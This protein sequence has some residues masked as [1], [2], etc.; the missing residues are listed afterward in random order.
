MVI[1]AKI[2]IFLDA[3]NGRKREEKHHSELFFLSRQFGLEEKKLIVKFS[4]NKTLI[5]RAKARLGH[6]FAQRLIRSFFSML[7]AGRTESEIA[8]EECPQN[9][10]SEHS[11]GI[12]AH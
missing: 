4:P 1:F 9:R 8:P 3:E 10:P 7:N 5:A 11:N 6:Y 12:S 2:F